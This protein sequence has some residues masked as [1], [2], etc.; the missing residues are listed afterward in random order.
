MTIDA[1]SASIFFD[2]AVFGTPATFFPVEGGSWP[3]DGI[4]SE[5]YALAQSGPGVAS[6]APIY[7]IDATTQPRTPTQDDRLTISGKGDFVVNDPQPDGS[8]LIRLI[9]ERA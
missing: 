5:A 8:G 4:Y 9:L 1:G 2:P 7:T 6:T 3:I